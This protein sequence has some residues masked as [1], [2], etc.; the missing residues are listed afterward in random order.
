[1]KIFLALANIVYNLCEEPIIEN[2]ELTELKQYEEQTD[3]ILKEEGIIRRAILNTLTAI[4]N[5]EE[6]KQ[7]IA[8]IFRVLSSL[9]D[10]L[11]DT[12]NDGTVDKNS[13]T[14]LLQQHALA[15]IER[16]ERFCKVNF[17][18]KG[19]PKYS[20]VVEK[21]NPGV[22]VAYMAVFTRAI[23]HASDITGKQHI[24]TII[25][26]ITSH[27]SSKQQAKL[28][29]SSFRNQYDHPSQ[30]TIDAIITLLDK[31]I[32]YLKGL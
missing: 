22:S 7:H 30:G 29:E 21:F 19:N 16:L 28:S 2:Q 1:M 9:S 4:V 5:G 3:A 10:I 15:T 11:N 31:M 25:R 20:A 24:V 6:Y 13:R 18:K 27:F 17:L 14:V 26:F 12:L 8:Y 23:V 32:H